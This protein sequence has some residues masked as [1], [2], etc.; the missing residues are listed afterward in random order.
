MRPL[1]ELFLDHF[2]SQAWASGQILH[3][4]ETIGGTPELKYLSNQ[5][6]RYKI[7]SFFLTKIRLAWE[8]AIIR[9]EL[10]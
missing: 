2:S 7:L 5:D 8:G 10:E 4:Q 3:P 6:T 1:F 9:V